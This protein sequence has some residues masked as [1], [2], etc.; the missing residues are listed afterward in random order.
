MNGYVK[1]IPHFY[2]VS[3]IAGVFLGLQGAAH[4]Q[5]ERSREAELRGGQGHGSDRRS[6]EVVQ[7]A[8]T[9]FV[10][11]AV[12]RGENLRATSA[13]VPLPGDFF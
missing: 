5:R 13:I 4:R 3:Q 1:N 6:G 9:S 12:D 7:V 10:Y 11:A 2:R 8:M